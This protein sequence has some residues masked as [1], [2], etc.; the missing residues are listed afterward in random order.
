MPLS[1]SKVEAL[2]RDSL[3]PQWV[4]EKERLDRID[5]WYRWEHEDPR[6]PRG[7]TAELKALL[8]LSKTPWLGLV[9]STV[10]QTL[11]VDGYRSPDA[12]DNAQ[13][14]R[15]WN[16]N[17]FDQRQTAIHRAAL[18]Y[19][20]S[21]VVVT[22]GQDGDGPRSVMR[23]VSPRK[24]LAVYGE[25]E[26][27]DW[28]IYFMQVAPQ[29]ALGWKIKVY[30]EDVLY[31]ADVDTAGK[32]TY[33]EYREHGAGV[34]PAVRYTN[35][36]DLDGRTPGEVEPLIPLAA[37]ID[38]TAYD[39]LLTQH[40]NSWKVRT[41]SGLSEFADN[42]EEANRKKLKLRQ[43][44]FLVAEDADTKFGTLDETSLAGFIEAYRADVG[45]LA[46][47]GQV[48]VTALNTSTIANLS[49][50]AIAELRAGLTQ[51]SFERQTSFGKSHAQ[52]LRLAAALEGDADSAADV[53]ARTT[54]QD[55]QTRSLSQAADAM[56][57]WVTM[58]GIPAEAAWGRLPGVTASDVAEWKNMASRGAAAARLQQVAE[59]AAAAR[60]N[61]RV[62]DMVT[63]RADAG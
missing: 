32:V 18:A 49:A 61:P 31:I 58:L 2:V 9:V 48:P 28:P 53:M 12:R 56:G 3:W 59:A 1:R 5:K 45:D 30:D 19:G 21:Y 33:N 63:R 7:A 37:K 62:A 25:P 8:E 15:T 23:G 17:D 11:F 55:M 16:A 14:W 20:H 4:K 34:C 52:A 24:G 6:L 60:Q 22:P 57:K 46:A 42:E 51:K 41:V 26:S 43:D 35:D 27:D 47:L 54:W 44:D 50:D 29:G 40:Y 39:R 36:L 13:V 38:K 10:A